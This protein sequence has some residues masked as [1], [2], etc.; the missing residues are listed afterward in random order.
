MQELKDLTSLKWSYIRKSSGT[1]GSFLKAYNE[2]CSQKIY[3]KL[4]NFET[5]I[6]ITGHECFNEI[7]VDRFCS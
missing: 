6:G 7:I 3:Y 4:S 5:G 1:A 2:K